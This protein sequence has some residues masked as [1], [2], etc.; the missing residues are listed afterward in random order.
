[1]NPALTTVGMGLRCDRVGLDRPG[2]VL[3]FISFFAISLSTSRLAPFFGQPVGTVTL[4]ITLTLLFRPLGALI[5]GLLSDRYG[6]RVP[7]HLNLDAPDA[8]AESGRSSPTW[9]S[10]LRFRCP[11]R[12]AR[13]SQ[14]SSPSAPW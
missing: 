8:V 9:Y 6:R 12:S 14:R 3:T 2:Q 11:R 10:S 13:R 5:F 4:S 7:T 1:M